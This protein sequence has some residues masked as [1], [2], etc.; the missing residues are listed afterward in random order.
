MVDLVD[1][2]S[3]QTCGLIHPE[4]LCTEWAQ[5]NGDEW[6]A[7]LASPRPL[8]VPIPYRGALG[9]RHTEDNT[10]ARILAQTGA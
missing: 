1:V 10:T 9:L 8:A 3:L 4:I 6:H 2:H 7:V 5:N